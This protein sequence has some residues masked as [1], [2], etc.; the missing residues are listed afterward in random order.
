V[1]RP[2]SSL[3]P[4]VSLHY[5]SPKAFT[6]RQSSRERIARKTLIHPIILEDKSAVFLDEDPW[7][8]YPNV[9]GYT[10]T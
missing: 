10:R 5:L 4:K 7:K 1:L 2:L 3:S 6:R 8:S 9:L